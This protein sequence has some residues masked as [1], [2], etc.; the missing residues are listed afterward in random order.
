[1]ALSRLGCMARIFCLWVSCEFDS[2]P[3]LGVAVTHGIKPAAQKPQQSTFFILGQKVCRMPPLPHLLKDLIWAYVQ[4]F[5]GQLEY[6][7]TLNAVERLQDQATYGVVTYVYRY[8]SIVI[9]YIGLFQETTQAPLFPLTCSQCKYTQ[10]HGPFRGES[11]P[12]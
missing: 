2:L 4:F 9:C 11:Q 10:V 7:M 1:M 12:G 5:L 8:K 3:F 6:T